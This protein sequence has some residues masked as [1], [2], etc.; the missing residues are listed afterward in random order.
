VGVPEDDGE[1]KMARWECLRKM[2]RVVGAGVPTYEVRYQPMTL[3]A[4]VRIGGPA[5][6]GA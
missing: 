4:V 5:D 1:R 2:A 3:D 6:F